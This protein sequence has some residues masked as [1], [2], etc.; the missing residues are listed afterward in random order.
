M[1]VQSE[2]AGWLLRRTAL[3][4]PQLSR[5]TSA[6]TFRLPHVLVLR[7]PARE[8]PA[9]EGSLWFQRDVQDISVTVTRRPRNRRELVRSISEPRFLA[10]DVASWALLH[11]AARAR[12]EK[13]SETPFHL[14]SEHK[15]S[16]S[17]RDGG[18]AQNSEARASTWL[19]YRGLACNMSLVPKLHAPSFAI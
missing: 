18:T 6:I 1:W 17:A 14:L 15:S 3:A 10:G 4:F 11:T 19:V 5:D 16:D 7:T 9:F 2:T 13:D 12:C 8:R